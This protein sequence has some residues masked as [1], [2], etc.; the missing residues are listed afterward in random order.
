MGN[1]IKATTG[2]NLNLED[3]DPTVGLEG[4]FEASDGN[5]S[6]TRKENKFFSKLRGAAS[7][8]VDFNPVTGTIETGEE[9]TTVGM[10][11]GVRVAGNNLG[12]GQSETFEH[13]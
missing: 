5:S 10:E 3:G 8:Q 1:C 12:Y 13:Q 7:D 6:N 4:N 2:V 9:E 11:T